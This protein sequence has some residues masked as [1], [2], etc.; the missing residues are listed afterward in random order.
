VGIHLTFI[1]T[2]VLFAWMDKIAG[3]GSDH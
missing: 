2:G 1:I 3:H